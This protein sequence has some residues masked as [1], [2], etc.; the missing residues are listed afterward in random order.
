M[1]DTGASCNFISLDIVR[2]LGL[3][4]GNVANYGVR[5]ANGKVLDTCGKVTMNIKFSGG[6]RHA[7]TFFVLDTD[8]P[9]ILGMQFLT[10]VDPDIDWNSKSVFVKCKGRYIQ[11][12]S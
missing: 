10:K 1:L 6:F 8:V 12:H 5:L 9:L 3:R 7:S 11:L 2:T 4:V